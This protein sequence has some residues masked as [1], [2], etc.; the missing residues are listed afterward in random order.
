VPEYPNPAFLNRLPDD[1]F[2]AAK[3]ILAFRDAEI[4]AIVRSAQYTDRKAEEWIAECLIQRRDKVGRAFYAKVLPIDRFTIR[5]GRLEFADLSEEAGF[6]G[7]GPYTIE[8]LRLNNESGAAAPIAGA[9]GAGLPGDGGPYRVARITSGARPK[10][11]V[12]VTVRV[13]GAAEV[14]G[15]ER[16]W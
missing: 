8:W 4:R 2:W 3:Q 10:Q 6:G 11:S 7:A 14:V 5:G 16:R 1:E 12:D 9:S 15:V 13:Q